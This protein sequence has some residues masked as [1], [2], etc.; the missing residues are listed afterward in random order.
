MFS[1]NLFRA[2]DIR[3]RYKQDFDLSFTKSLAFSLCDLAKQKG[4]IKPKFLIGQDARLSS[5]EISQALVQH[6]KNQGAGVAFIGL[7]PSPLCYFLLYHYNLTACIVITASHN[8]PEDNGFKILFHKK[9]KI[10]DPIQALKNLFLEKRFFHKKASRQK[11]YEFKIKKEE[12]YISS[13]KKEFSFNFHPSFVIDT[14]N[15][16][17]GP[18]A[19]KA[20]SALGLKPEY[21]F[22]EP[23][24]H[25]PNHHPDPTV[26]KNLFHLKIK[27]KK[28][29]FA[30]GFAFDGDGD[31]LT[32]VSKEGETVLGDTFGYLFLKSLLKASKKQ[33][34]TALILADVKC[35]DWFF[36]SAKKEG[37]KILM[38]KSGHRLIRREMEKTGALLA[39][40]FSGHVFFNDRKE[41]GFDDA[42][43]ASL[44]LLELL[45]EKNTKL[46][47]LLPKISSVKTGEIR[48]DMP[49]QEISEKL[50][51]IQA[52]LKQKGE[53]FKNIDGLRISRAR[54]WALFRSS[55]TQ[56]ALTMRFEA[57]SKKRACSNEIRIFQSNRILKFL[58]LFYVFPWLTVHLTINKRVFMSHFTWTH[59]YFLDWLGILSLGL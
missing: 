54:S 15:G 59:L 55:K 3:G 50:L 14:G 32:V 28:G 39:L 16:A 43:Y 13:L 22:Y 21:L 57:P 52:Y 37:F 33:K 20:F 23:D 29:G 12:P 36:D 1:K 30:L 2:N 47:S 38:T 19:K 34:R 58:K 53:S 41:R 5:P 9:H 40:E 18:L 46:T 25:F 51:K 42:L 48:I 6:L 27:I 11:G 56:E 45:S 24:G 7:A 35:S 31:R 4:V 10:F 49:S 26:E 44:R 8:P 17:L